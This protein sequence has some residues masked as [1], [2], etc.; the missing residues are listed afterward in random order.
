M[1]STIAKLQ[2]FFANWLVYFSGLIVCGGLI[3]YI[4]KINQEIKFENIRSL[5]NFISISV[6]NPDKF[7]SVIG[8][9][10]L[11][12]FLAFFIVPI[13]Y[14]KYFKVYIVIPIILMIITFVGYYLGYGV[15]V[16]FINSV[17]LIVSVIIVSVSI[18]FFL[19]SSEK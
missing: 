15:E 19:P 2:K 12:I 18:L 11:F 1:K 6:T 5:K 9:S 17:I 13:T 16:F 7:F 8:A 10:L 14:K 3:Y 4:L